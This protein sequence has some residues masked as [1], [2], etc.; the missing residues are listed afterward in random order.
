MFVG[1]LAACQVAQGQLPRVL[2]I[3]EGKW[4]VRLVRFERTSADFSEYTFTFNALNRE[5]GAQATLQL[6]DQ[7]TDIDKV[8]IVGSKLV[9]LG[10]VGS[11]GDIVS[12][13]DLENGEKLDEFLCWWP[14]MSSTGRYVVAVGFLPRFTDSALKS[15]FVVLYDLHGLGKTSPAGED[16]SA[17]VLQIFPEEGGQPGKSNEKEVG[18]HSINMEAGFLWS[19]KDDRL[20]FVDRYLGDSWLVAIDLMEGRAKA[21]RRHPLDVASILSLPKNDPSYTETLRRERIGIPIR[22]MYWDG[23]DVVVVQVD[24]NRPGQGHLYRTDWLR[25][26]V[27]P[28]AP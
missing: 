26:D 23:G 18:R 15:H 12:V 5:S 28:A 4:I 16:G 1:F 27:A 2:S 8:E 10:S 17:R 3:E 9:V 21:V 24:R 25:V 11:S 7:T 13:F 19:K 6:R 14:R 22:G 20:V